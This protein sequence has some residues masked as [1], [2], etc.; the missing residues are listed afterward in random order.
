MSALQLPPHREIP[1]LKLVVGS[2]LVGSGG[3]TPT[4]TQR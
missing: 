1:W 4:K 2:I 3:E